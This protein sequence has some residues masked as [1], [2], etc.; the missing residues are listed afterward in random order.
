MPINIQVSEVNAI[1]GESYDKDMEMALMFTS[2]ICKGECHSQAT[3]CMSLISQL[4]EFL[5]L[6]SVYQGVY[7]AFF[8]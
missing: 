5:G 7:K 6:N 3:T 1:S 2:W 4:C 8:G